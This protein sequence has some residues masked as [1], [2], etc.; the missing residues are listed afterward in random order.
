[1][2]QILCLSYEPWQ[3]SPSRTQ[4]LISRLS[5][6]EI[7][8]FEPPTTRTTPVQ[9]QG[10][11][12]RSHISVYTLPATPTVGPIRTFSQRWALRRNLSFI[13][14]V[15]E[16]HRFHTPV[17][18]CTSPVYSA[19]ADEISCSGVVYD[20]HC[21]WSE[22]YIGQESDLTNRAEVVFAASP[23]LVNRLS[24][25]S[26]NIALLPNGVNPLMF[27]RDEFSLPEDLSALVGRTVLGRVGDITTQTDLEPML[28]AAR[29]RP[30][31]TFLLIGRVTKQASDLLS[32]YPNIILLGPVN[33]A[34]LPDHL[35]VCSALFDLLQN[36]QRGSDVLSSRI[37][38]YLAIGKPIV[39]MAVPDYNEPFP[40][41]IYTAFDPVGFLRR[42]DKAVS[43]ASKELTALRK[44]YAAQCAWS[45]RA[46]EVER[47]FESTGLYR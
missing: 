28:R 35:S 34:E 14:S 37:Y 30:E 22:E 6:A 11:R 43:E 7:L 1:M 44:S 13:R 32:H 39:M 8:F 33:A 21:E 19:L 45:V 26:D 29:E 23:S 4:Q 42:C 10:R 9:K 38:E 40:D 5:A 47:I 3:A 18:W 46:A 20:C 25:C 15:M 17:L 24:P 36:D 41:A 12:M 16:K 2:K 31:W 27:D